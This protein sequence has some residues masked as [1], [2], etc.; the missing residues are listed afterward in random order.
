MVPSVAITTGAAP[1]ARNVLNSSARS[2]SCRAMTCPAMMRAAKPARPPNTASAIASGLMARSALAIAGAFVVKP[3]AE[4]TAW[5]T[6]P[7]VV[8]SDT[9]LAT[10]RAPPESCRAL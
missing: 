5:G 4:I 3:T 9:T 10:L 7:L 2:R 6:M 8:I 1:R